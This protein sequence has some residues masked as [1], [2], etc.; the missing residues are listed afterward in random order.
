MLLVELILFN[1]QQF[2]GYLDSGYLD[3]MIIMLRLQQAPSGANSKQHE[4]T[5]RN[6]L[7]VITTA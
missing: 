7:T 3:C 1:K 5:L 4:H 6:A 2:S